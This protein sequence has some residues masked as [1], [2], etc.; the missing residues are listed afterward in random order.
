MDIRRLLHRYIFASFSRRCIEI[1]AAVS[2]EHSFCAVRFFGASRR[3]Q[4]QTR[5]TGKATLGR[6]CKSAAPCK[7][8]CNSG[9]GRERAGRDFARERDERERRITID[10]NRELPL[11]TD[12]GRHRR[13]QSLTSETTSICD[14]PFARFTLSPSYPLSV[15]LTASSRIGRAKN[16]SVRR[17]TRFSFKKK[18]KTLIQRD[19]KFKAR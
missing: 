4:E 6:A 18:K 14:C 9:R 2:F 10:T 15:S 17:K 13:S 8:A 16:F 1:I 7:S 5:R 19:R 11:E 3:F 12:R